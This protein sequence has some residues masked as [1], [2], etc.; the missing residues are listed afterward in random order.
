MKKLIAIFLVLG[1]VLS[2]VDISAQQSRYLVLIEPTG[3]SIDGMPEMKYIPDTSQIYHFADSI[4]RITFIREAIE[5]FQLAQQYAFNKGLI[6]QIEP[7]YLAV[8]KNQGGFARQGF[9]LR[10]PDDRVADKSK[11]HYVDLTRGTLTSSPER[12]SSVTQIYPHE[13]MHAI[14]RMLCSSGLEEASSYNV[15]MHYFS[16]I[17]DY[18]T[19]FNEGFAEHMEAVSQEFEP[20]NFI[21]EGR[22]REIDSEIERIQPR[23]DGF[24]R[25]CGWPFRLGYYKAIMLLWYQPFE[26]YKR[27]VYV[28]GDEATFVNFSPDLKSVRDRITW[29]NTGIDQDKSRKKNLVQMMANEG[30][31]STFFTQ[32]AMSELKDAYRQADFYR[33]FRPDTSGVNNP[34][35]DLSPLQNLFMKYFYVLDQSVKFG[36]SEK[37]QFIDFIDGYCRIFPE[38]AHVLVRIFKG[39]TGMDYT[40][41]LPPPFWALVKDY[42]HPSLVMDPYGAMTVPVYTFDINAAEEEDFRTIKGISRET[43]DKII[44]YRNVNGLF[45]S[46]DEFTGIPGLNRDEADLISSLKMDD[47]Y[48][49]SLPETNM[50]IMALITTPLLNL[51]KNGLLFFIPFLG[52]VLFV[53]R[54]LKPRRKLF[55]TIIRY[56][57]TWLLFL[58]AGLT[59]VVFL[60]TPEISL[61]IFIVC[62]LFLVFLVYRKKKEA[63]PRNIIITALM[64]LLVTYFVV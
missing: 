3:D 48:F 60:K 26:D 30:F 36:S 41:E 33:Q 56:F 31:I 58:V 10:M 24:R 19:A 38:E 63:L 14:Y 51:L 21:K 59:A 45:H 39:L 9:F 15:N 57:L 47:A 42:K 20:D 37:S 27:N 62:Y 13:L 7:A 28:F 22:K 34:L 53:Y 61:S 4:S 25:D 35:E 54:G 52:I 32:L 16:V 64:G 18:N 40:S 12:L 29:R 23:I 49:E 46:W 8:T 6:E 44:Q 17:T 50:D 1:C 43:A 5:L 11:A 55:S 2:A